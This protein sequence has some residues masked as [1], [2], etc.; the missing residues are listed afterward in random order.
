PL[1]RFLLSFFLFGLAPDARPGAAMI[2]RAEEAVVGPG[3][4]RLG[5][6]LALVERVDVTHAH[7]LHRL[8]PGDAP[9]LAHEKAAVSAVKN[10][11]RIDATALGPVGQH[12]AHLTADEAGVAR[13]IALAAV[14]ADQDAEIFGAEVDPIRP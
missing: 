5:L 11:A 7:P 8:L 13:L 1:R 4:D 9:V 3:V 14:I 2:V 10:H 6:R 12:G